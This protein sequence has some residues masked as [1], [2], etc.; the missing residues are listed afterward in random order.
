MKEFYADGHRQRDGLADGFKVAG[1]GVDAEDL[2]VIRVLMAGEEPA[3]GGVEVEVARCFAAAGGVAERGEGAVAGVDGEAGQA[4]VAAVAAVEESAQRVDDDRPVSP[5]GRV[6]TFCSR[7]SVPLWASQGQTLTV[8]SS[9]L[10][11]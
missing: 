5:T 1:V 3:A 2:N 9:S 7:C 8:A 11:L 6:E 10:M 4:V